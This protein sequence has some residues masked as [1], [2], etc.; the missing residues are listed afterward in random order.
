MESIYPFGILLYMDEPN[1]R[2]RE[3]LLPETSKK[4]VGTVGATFLL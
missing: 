4:N 2:K 1:C 3:S